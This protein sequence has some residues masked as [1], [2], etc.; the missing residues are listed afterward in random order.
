[1]LSLISAGFNVLLITHLKIKRQWLCLGGTDSHFG[2][3]GLTFKSDQEALE[4]SSGCIIPQPNAYTLISK[5][6]TPRH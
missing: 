6:V 5:D 2:K 3:V 4:V 1:M